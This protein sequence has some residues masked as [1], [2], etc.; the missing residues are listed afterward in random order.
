MGLSTSFHEQMQGIHA[1][2]LI[3]SSGNAIDEK[4]ILPFLKQEFPKL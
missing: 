4:A 3:K 1:Q 2:L